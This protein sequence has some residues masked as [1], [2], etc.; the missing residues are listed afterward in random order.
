MDSSAQTHAG[1]I[2]I[3]SDQGDKP[4]LDEM[5]VWYLS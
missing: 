5:V 2:E 1:P 3:Y 4:M